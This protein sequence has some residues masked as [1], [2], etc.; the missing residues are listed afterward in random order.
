MIWSVCHAFLKVR[1][2]SFAPNQKASSDNQM[3]SLGNK[4][5][6]SKKRKASCEECWVCTCVKSSCRQ[7]LSQVSHAIIYTRVII[8]AYGDA[9]IAD[10]G[11]Q[12][13]Q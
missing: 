9:R 3:V 7:S 6:L 4:K 10:F 8:T 12:G 5:L 13:T 2:Y 11:K 1:L